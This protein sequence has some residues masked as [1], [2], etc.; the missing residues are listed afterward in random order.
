MGKFSGRPASAGLEG[1]ALRLIATDGGSGLGAAIGI[2]YPRAPHQRCWAHKLR[3]VATLLPRKIQ[4]ACLRGA[5]RIYQADTARQAGQRF[6]TW[7]KEW[8]EQAPQG[9][10]LPGARSRGVAELLRL[11]RGGLEE[12]AH[13][14]CH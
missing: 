10:G 7:K 4:A 8:H 5:K 14:E 12:N 2:V 9:G 13:D 1:T 6:R 3:N 11:S